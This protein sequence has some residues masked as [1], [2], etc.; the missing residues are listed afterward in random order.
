MGALGGSAGCS[1]SRPGCKG[2]R[3]VSAPR[4]TGWGFG[5]K[6][7]V[8]SATSYGRNHVGATTYFG[9]VRCLVGG[10]HGC[11]GSRFFRTWG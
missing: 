1:D 8:T 3:I 5:S 4:N 9:P 11:L 7:L 2:A 10:G 6:A